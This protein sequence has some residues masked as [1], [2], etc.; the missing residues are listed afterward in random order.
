MDVKFSSAK[1]ALEW[2]WNRINGSDMPCITQSCSAKLEVGSAQSGGFGPT[3]ADECA[4]AVDL[5]KALDALPY[6]KGRIIYEWIDAGG[7]DDAIATLKERYSPMARHDEGW[8]SYK[9]HEILK[10]LGRYL[11][12]LDYLKPPMAA[13]SH[14]SPVA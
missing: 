4:A 11:R 3:M 7:D 2:Y 13:H 5:R 12:R 9:L 1:H 14:F 10:E 8:I 6:F